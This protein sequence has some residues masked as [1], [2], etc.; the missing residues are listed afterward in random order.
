MGGSTAPWRQ[1]LNLLAAEFGEA[2][3]R[4]EATTSGAVW[5]DKC[6]SKS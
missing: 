5:T 3:A 4:V 6:K 2:K 1:A